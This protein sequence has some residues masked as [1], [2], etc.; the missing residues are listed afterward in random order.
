MATLE[1]DAPELILVRFGEL[2]LKKGNRAAFEKTLA[3]NIKAATRSIAPVDVL[4]RGGRMIVI[5]K[6]RGLAIARRLQDVF[7]IKSVSPAWGAPTEPDAIAAVAKTMLADA[8]AEIPHRPVTFRVRTRRAEK[9]F[10]MHS[11]ELDKYVADRILPDHADIKVQLKRPELELGIDLRSERAYLFIKR[12]PGPGGLPVGTLGRALCLLSG[13]IDSPVAAWL[14]MKRGCQVGFVT[15][16]SAPFIGEA[17]KKKVRDLVRVLSTFQD[18]GRLYVAPFAN[19]QIAI[20]DSAPASYR[21]VLYRRMM[22]RIA[23][24]VSQ[25]FEYQALVTG[26]CLGQVAS[27]TLENMTCIGDA[28]DMPILRPLLSFDKEETIAIARRIGTFDISNIQE[29]DCCVVFQPERPII[30]GT[31]EECE[32]AESHLDVEG[33]VAEAVDGLEIEDLAA[34]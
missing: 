34:E 26:E 28:T 11:N 20:R 31:I 9:R 27:Q 12:L 8:M 13:G 17:S 25:K 10:P 21:T 2:A 15:Y 19:I 3:R 33:L 14:T 23:T 7:G 5:P 22:Q 32:A 18:S 30:R 6:R 29:P 16:H 4:R 1:L 24:R